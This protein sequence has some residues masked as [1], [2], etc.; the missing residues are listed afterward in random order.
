MLP[1]TGDVLTRARAALVIATCLG[2]AISILALIL[3][4]LI[5]R[6]LQVETAI[7]GTI[8]IGLLAGIAALA[9]SG[10]VTAAT[11]ILILLL[12]LLITLTTAPYGLGSP[13]SVAYAI[14]A[15]L[16]ACGLGLWAGLGIAT[17]GSAIIWLVAWATTSGLYEP[18]SAVDISHL[19]FNAPAMT[20]ILMLVTLI[21][22]VYTRYLERAIRAR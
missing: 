21:A 6:D 8:L 3:T 2:L 14:P 4:W 16:A 22:G 10:R 12:T 1:D 19:T 15:V 18:W 7:A 13:T 5:S 20:V 9:C 11:W 17:L